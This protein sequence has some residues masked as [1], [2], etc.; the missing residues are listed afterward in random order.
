MTACGRGH[1][2]AVQKAQ[3][4]FGPRSRARVTQGDP[5]LSVAGKTSLWEPPGTR[6][7]TCKSHARVYKHPITTDYKTVCAAR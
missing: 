7:H 2:C 4:K 3:G 1:L 5:G 6:L